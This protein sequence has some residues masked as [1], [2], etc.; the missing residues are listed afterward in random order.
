MSSV[1]SPEVGYCQPNCLSIS[2]NSGV[3][4]ETAGKWGTAQLPPGLV[5]LDA[6][7]YSGVSSVACAAPATCVAAGSYSPVQYF[8]DGFLAAELPG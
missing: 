3:S 8:T 1:E 5:K 4:S 2:L 7:V 6:A